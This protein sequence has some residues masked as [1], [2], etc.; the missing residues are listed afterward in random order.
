MAQAILR[1]LATP[2]TTAVLPCMLIM[3][4]HTQQ[5]RATRQYRALVSEYLIKHQV[6][7]HA[8]NRDV[9]PDG[10]GP[11]GNRTMAVEEGSKPAR[12]CD[13]NQGRHCGG[14]QGVRRK[15]GEVERTCPPLSLKVHTAN[16]GV[17]IDLG[18]ED[19]G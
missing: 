7:H 15:D 1:L 9:H 17:V 3:A 13:Q 16:V 14:K 4:L 18:R 8:S 12:E 5:G 2:N 10:V 6:D 11:L 19:Q